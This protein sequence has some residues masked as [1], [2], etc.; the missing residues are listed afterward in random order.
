ME[1]W[2]VRAGLRHISFSKLFQM[3][4]SDIDDVAMRFI[5]SLK[6]G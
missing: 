2:A 6:Q 4:C 3:Q 5:I 1:S